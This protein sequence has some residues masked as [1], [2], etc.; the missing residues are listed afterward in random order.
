MI[1]EI[2]SM[3]YIGKE[4]KWAIAIKYW[5]FVLLSYIVANFIMTSI[6]G[7]ITILSTILYVTI[8]YLIAK[9]IFNKKNASTIAFVALG[10]NIIVVWL[11]I[12]FLGVIIIGLLM[13]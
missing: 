3:R 5:L 4:K 10:I 2:L 12:A 7:R 11:L 1:G 9:N 8:A 6:I 13:L